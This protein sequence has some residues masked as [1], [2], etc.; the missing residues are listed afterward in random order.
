VGK[1]KKLLVT[2][3]PAGRP[4]APE[5]AEAQAALAKWAEGAASHDNDARTMAIKVRTYRNKA[6]LIR[7]FWAVDQYSSHLAE[8]RLRPPGEGKSHAA[9]VRAKVKAGANGTKAVVAE[10]FIRSVIDQKLA[11]A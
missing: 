6:S 5:L 9:R 8:H 1:S 4:F 7:E 3:G 2:K 10:D 11:E